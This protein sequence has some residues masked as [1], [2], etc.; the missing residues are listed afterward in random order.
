MCLSQISIHTHSDIAQMRDALDAKEVAWARTMD[1]AESDV[2]KAGRRILITHGWMRDSID[3]IR[4]S[5][6]VS[7]RKMSAHGHAVIESLVRLGYDLAPHPLRAMTAEIDAAKNLC[8]RLEYKR[9]LW[10]EFR[11][12]LAHRKHL[13]AVDA[14]SSTVKQFVEA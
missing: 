12:E 4:W 7:G 13:R 5:R 1:D 2:I 3:R 14:F 8:N 11:A 9:L 10:S 6:Y